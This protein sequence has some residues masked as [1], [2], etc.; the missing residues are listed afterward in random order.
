[1]RIVSN[2]L[3]ELSIEQLQAAIRG[4]TWALDDSESNEDTEI[5]EQTLWMLETELL[6]RGILPDKAS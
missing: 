2:R 5:V 3:R 1:M 6:T 4:L